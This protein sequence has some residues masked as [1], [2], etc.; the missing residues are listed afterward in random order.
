MKAYLELLQ[1]ILDNGVEKESG[2][3][4]MPNT[5]GISSGNIKMDMK[6]GFPLLTTK[7]MFLKGII[8]ELLW[9]LKGDTN[10]KYLVD[11]GVNIWSS[12]AYRWYLKWWDESGVEQGGLRKMSIEEFILQ[13][14]QSSNPSYPWIAGEREYVIGD[15]GKVYGYQ[16]RNQ[17]GVDQVKDV[18]DGLKNNPY[19]RYH[20]IDGWN[21]Q[22]FKFMALPPCHLLYQFIV[23]PLSHEKRSDW[24]SW[25]FDNLKNWSDVEMD[26]EYVP[27]FYL[28]LNMYQR[29]CDACCGIP[30]NLASMSLLLMIFAK[31]SNMIPSISNWIGGDTHIYLPHIETAKEQIKRI[32]LSLP[33]IRIKKDLKSLE[34][35]LNL[36]ISDFELTDYHSYDKI[37]YKL[38]TGLKKVKD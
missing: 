20:I 24:A 38:F 30:F 3:E 27:K 2:R 18:L 29:S 22:D 23:R 32:P 31:A 16:W 12:D 17:N 15:L 33:N 9:I 5:F 8:T 35:I 28:D 26:E 7:K 21:K 6:D 10:I 34:D 37:V 14:K 13:I 11:N 19:S 4:N 1:N 25:H 36:S